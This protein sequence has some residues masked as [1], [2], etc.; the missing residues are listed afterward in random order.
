MAGGHRQSTVDA[1]SA[2]GGYC[3]LFVPSPCF[4][5]RWEESRQSVASRFY[6]WRQQ[7]VWD[8][9]LAQLQQESDGKVR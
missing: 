1:N 6:R 3:A 2:F 4:A 8:K 9:V 5:Y 7:G